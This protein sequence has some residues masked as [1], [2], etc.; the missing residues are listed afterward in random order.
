MTPSF[1][2]VLIA[3]NE[4][5]SLSRL[6][7][8]LTEFQHRGGEIILVDT[9]STDGTAALARSL[10]CKVFEEGER[11]ITVI[12]THLAKHINK[13]FI[14]HGEDDIVKV[15]DK[16]FDYASA[17][18]YAANLANHSMVS[19]PDCDEEFTKL[20]LDVI[21]QAINEGYNR[22]EYNFVF[23]HDE[24]G[25]E[26]IKFMHSK[27]YNR[28]K[29]HWVGVVHEVLTGETKNKFFNENE[30]KL[31][32]W[33]NPS[34]HRSRYLT[35]LALDCYQNLN[36]DR[37]SHYL[38]RE[39]V[40]TGRPKSA[41][42][43]FDRHIAMNAWL[44]EKA[45]SM[46]FKG[47]AYVALGDTDKALQS[48]HQAID[49]DGG[50]REAWLRIADYYW[51][52]ND[53]LH[54]ACYASAALNIPWNNFYCN[55]MDHY[56]YAPHKI[57]YWAKWYLGEKEESKKHWQ[58]CMEYQPDNTQFIHDWIF[59]HNGPKVSIV[60][61]TLGREEQL[62]RLLGLIPLTANYENYEIIV[63]EDSFDD[64]QGALKLV[65]KGVDKSAGDLVMFLGNDCV[66][67]Q[68]FLINAVRA[69]YDNFGEEMD[70][71]IGLNDGYWNGEFATHWLASKKLLPYLDGE[72]FHTG[73]Y[74]AGCDNELTE[75]CRVIGK[76]AWASN[77]KV[78]N[79]TQFDEVHRIAYDDTRL[80]HDRDLLESRSKLLGFELHK[81]FERPKN[82][83]N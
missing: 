64:R 60:I 4:T 39:L 24:F 77:A 10:G 54:A 6:V 23:S 43:E 3:R 55:Y 45:Q 31:E 72:F 32:H 68:N 28:N 67:H 51:K 65:K 40:W 59:Y 50:R 29:C 38:A 80:K 73:Y 33:Q 63:M 71:L 49:T 21:E 19:M 2:V 27:F 82:A 25:K 46:I 5:K 7:K 35:G 52:K 37:N 57:L 42:R 18:N 8:S 83:I 66:P 53:F 20:D 34:E 75:R 70:G 62:K 15:G 26:V 17:R 16:L 56:T 11:F 41:I 48:W 36:N 74:H 69:M 30:I 1:S 61:P 14:V 44:P 79:E 47:D 81:N 12:D 9:G 13:K 58:K 76:Y 78:V 22:F